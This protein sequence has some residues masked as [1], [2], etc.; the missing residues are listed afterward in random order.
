VFAIT[1]TPAAVLDYVFDW[2]DWLPE[3]DTITACA[4]AC[5]DITKTGES[6]TDHT[7]T[8]WLTGGEHGRD[9]PVRCRVTTAQGRMDDYT[10]LLRVRQR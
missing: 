8:V 10:L 2:S 3:G 1:K 9:Y 4:W 6:F 7:T 5:G